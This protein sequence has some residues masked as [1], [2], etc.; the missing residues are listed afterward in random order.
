MNA[1]IA[2][3]GDPVDSLGADP[4]GAL[5]PL[6]PMGAVSSGALW[7]LREGDDREALAIAQKIGVDL[8]LARVLVAR[9][10]TLESAAEYLSPSLRRS[11][12][13]PNILQDMDKAAKRLADA[14]LS[15][16]QVGIFGDYDV[17][18]TTSAA[19]LKT[20]FDALGMPLLVYLPDRIT[21]GYGPNVDAFRSLKADGAEIVVTVD[22]GATADEVINAAAQDGLE[23]IVIDHHQMGATLPSG[24]YAVVNPNRADDISGLKDLS[25]AGLSFLA[26]IALN[27]VLRERGFFEDRKEPDLLKLLDLTALGLVCDV[28]PMTGLTRIL[29]AQGLKLF[30]GDGNPGLKSLAKRAGA[31]GPASGYH[32]G[33]LL[34][35]RI[36]AAGR[37]GHA[38]LAFDLLTTP[39]PDKRENLAEKLHTMNA[40]RQAIERQVQDEALRDIESHQRQADNVIITAGEGW[41]PGVIGIVAGRLK[42]IFQKPVLVIG[43]EEGE[44]KGSGRSI[45]GVDL[46]K[47]IA[48][49]REAGTL[50]S[51]GGHAMAAGLSIERSNIEKLRRTLNAQLGDD[52]AVAR[53]NR[54]VYLDAVIAPSAVTKAFADLIAAAGP[55]GPGNPEPQFVLGNMRVRYPKV[56]GDDHLSVTLV[57]ETGEEVRAIAFRAEGKTLGEF[58]RDGRR[59]HLAGKVK[60]DDWRGGNAGQFQITDAAYAE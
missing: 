27:R 45:S 36:N 58:L 11:L 34:G 33:F 9:G 60:P 13:D 26:V 7:I 1:R 5:L 48:A 46:G 39:E 40:E 28:M 3:V 21:E 38:Q 32:L 35:P 53:E 24:A 10:V 31:K 54:S 44:G 18:G 15:G 29:V 12:P 19:I 42:D 56:V 57:S 50:K 23:I 17:D 6:P 22:C 59:I 8:L 51:G 47:A 14:V 16:E 52:V 41:H 4:M 20:Y 55:F 43:L 37:I 30:D 49:A 2:E 25:A